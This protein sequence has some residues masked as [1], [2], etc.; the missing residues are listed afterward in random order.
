MEIK[1]QPSS[2]LSVNTYSDKFMKYIIVFLCVLNMTESGGSGG[3]TLTRIVQTRFGKIQGFVKPMNPNRHLKPIE[4]FLGVP[5]ATP[6]TGGNRFGPTR[7]ASPWDGVKLADKMGASCPQQLPD[8]SNETIALQTM[9]VGRLQYLR[10]LL[11]YLRNQSEDCLF[12]NIYAPAQ[13]N[14]QRILLIDYN[15]LCVLM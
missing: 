4:V 9:P 14:K 12:L 15:C 5:Y 10:R 7:T 8:I 1:W 2:V 6:P 11:P 3:P 13:G